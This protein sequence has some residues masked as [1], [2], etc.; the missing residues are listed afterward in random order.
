MDPLALII[1]ALVGKKAIEGVSKANTAAKE[2]VDNNQ[3]FAQGV[4]QAGKII[5]TGAGNVMQDKLANM[6]TPGGAFIRRGAYATSN[7]VDQ[8][9]NIIDM[10]NNGNKT[11]S[12]ETVEV[13]AEEEPAKPEEPKKPEEKESAEDIVTYTYKPGDTFGQVLLNLGLSDGTNLW[14][15]GGDVDFYTQQLREQNALNSLGNIPIG[16]TIRLRRRK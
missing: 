6:I 7:L 12:T 13:K 3:E 11:D 1:N 5:A 10:N 16:T 15:Q 9:K 4:N 14:G 8:I 2:W